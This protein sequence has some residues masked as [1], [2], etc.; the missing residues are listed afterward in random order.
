MGTLADILGYWGLYL[1]A[2]AGMALSF[3]SNAVETGSYR[4]NRIRLRLRADAGDRRAATVLRLV[5]DLRG[6]IVTILVTNN[7][8]HFIAAAA[9]TTL[10][11]QAAVTRSDLFVELVSTAIAAPLL[12]VFCELLPKN[13]FA[14]NP[15]D[16]LCRLAAA[17]RA[18]YR[19]LYYVGLV[20]AL[21]GLTTL[22]LRL[23]GTKAA[24]RANPFNPRQRLR[25]L[26]QESAAEGVISGYQGELVEKVLALREQPVR[27]VMIPLSHVAAVPT[28][29]ARDDFLAAVR[30]HSHARLPVYEGA[31][32]NIVGIVRTDDVLAAEGG[33]LDLPAVMAR[34]VLSVPADLPVS[35]ALFRMQKAR[36]AMAVV[37]D[38]RGRPLGIITIKDLVEEIV[39][40]LGAW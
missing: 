34:G 18:T 31:R 2:L 27:R 26:M 23:A 21:K 4:V 6:L 25:A 19:G 12:F 22:I 37:R 9:L 7:V 14:F 8:A 11:A 24:E 16:R 30:L 32:E 39:G 35:Q 33:T 36:A 20:P 3:L 1:A 13:V 5:R 17:V 10:V 28:N 15:E 29:V 38:A 40:E